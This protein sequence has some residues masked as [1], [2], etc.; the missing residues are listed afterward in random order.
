[1]AAIGPVTAA[2]AAELGIRTTIMPDTY[3]V[4]ALVKKLVE[5]FRR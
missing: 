3:T 1:V 2:A 5:H 4:D